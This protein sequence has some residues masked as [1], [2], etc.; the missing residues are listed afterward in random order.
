[1]CNKVVDSEFLCDERHDTI[2]EIGLLSKDQKKTPKKL[3][4]SCSDGRWDDDQN[5]LPDDKHDTF[6]TVEVESE[7]LKTPPEQLA[8]NSGVVGPRNC[9]S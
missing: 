5:G 1:M 6:G 4:T 8:T 7:L 2:R 9:G 3:M